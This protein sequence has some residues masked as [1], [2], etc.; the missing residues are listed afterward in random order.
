LILLD[1][2][3]EDMEIILIAS[4]WHKLIKEVKTFN[5]NFKFE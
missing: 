5:L 3:I 2:F 1:T 4:K